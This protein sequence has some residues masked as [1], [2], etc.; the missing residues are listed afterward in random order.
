MRIT[1][2]LSDEEYEEIKEMSK[3]FSRSIASQIRHLAMTN[4]EVIGFRIMSHRN[5]IDAKEKAK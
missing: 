4:N 5:Q 2:S 3:V 1:V